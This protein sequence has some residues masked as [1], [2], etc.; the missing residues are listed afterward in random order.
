MTVGVCD[1][2]TAGRRKAPR[3]GGGARVV[4]ARKREEE[5]QNPKRL[6]ERVSS[7]A[8]RNTWKSLR[9]VT[10]WTCESR[11][12]PERGGFYPFFFFR[13]WASLFSRP[14]RRPSGSGRSKAEHSQR[15]IGEK[16]QEAGSECLQRL[17]LSES[18]AP[19]HS[20]PEWVDLQR[21][22]PAPSGE[23]RRRVGWRGGKKKS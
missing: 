8:R 20:A 9:P 13:T 11:L 2:T 5:K 18:R 15:V 12:A 19:V 7:A 21:D 3:G 17:E 22:A 23:S 4:L 10:T 1:V 6:G 14:P 16:G